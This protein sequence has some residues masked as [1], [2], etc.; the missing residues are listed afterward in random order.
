MSTKETIIKAQ[1][2]LIALGFPCGAD[3]A[4]GVVG[5]MTIGATTRYQQFAGLV[6][7]GV[8]DAETLRSLGVQT[9]V[10]IIPWLEEAERYLGLK[11]LKGSNSN[12]EI[13]RWAK[14]LGGWV[15]GYYKGDDIP[16]CGLFVAHCIGVS[17]PK[18]ALPSN[19][20]GA[21]NWS[22]WGQALSVPSQGSIMA[23]KR[24]GGG[25]VGMYLGEND[26]YYYIIGGN[27]SDSVSKM[28]IDKSRLADSPRWP[29]T[30]PQPATGRI[31]IAQNGQPISN[32]EA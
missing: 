21:L 25:H 29:R 10:A 4:D 8:L 23:F 3:G 20:L 22:T 14:D 24:E 16:W 32:N 7:N 12:P 11:E 28:F 6:T 2:R 19:P 18:E 31:Q 5:R 26:K 17:L 9:S 30:V 1:E 13:I 27:Q 15:G